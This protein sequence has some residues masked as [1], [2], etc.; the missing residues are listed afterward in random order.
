LDLNIVSAGSL[1]DIE[2]FEHTRFKTPELYFGYKF[3]AGRNQLGNTPNF[4]P[5]I[6]NAFKFPD[7]IKQNFFYLDGTWKSLEGSMRLISDEG[8]ILLAYTAKEV[9]IVTEN[10]A[11]LRIF[12]DGEIIDP[13]IAG[14]DVDNNGFVLTTDDDL[15]NIVTT[16][17]SEQH[18]IQIFVDTPGFE[19]YTFTFG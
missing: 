17:N 13:S 16:E 19:I 11:T 5:E 2:E 9:N 18:I 6:E 14:V 10:E 4:T 15:Y 8:S 1:V 12:I 7:E 3:A